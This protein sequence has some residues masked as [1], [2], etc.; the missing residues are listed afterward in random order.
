MDEDGSGLGTERTTLKR[1]PERGVHDFETIACILDE[2]LYCHI[3]F[4]AD[5]QP[6]V[7]PTAFGRSGRTLYIHGSAASR[8]L[9]ALS[10]G[11]SMCLTATL[12][13]GLV[14]A[15]SAFRHSMNY[16]AVMILGVAHEV[17]GEEKLRGLETITE[18]T[19]PGRW[20]DARPPSAKELK[21]TT[22]LK[23]DIEEASAKIRQGPPIDDEADYALPIW[24]GEIPLAIAVQEPV[25]DAK[26][27]P[28]VGLPAYLAD[29]RR[30][31]G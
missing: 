27:R 17:S 25:P 2:A 22:V 23:L 10:G 24:A 16:R 26:L 1:H 31:D 14:L 9:G 3:G 13:D 21:A 28:D 6:F 4:V 15:R 20:A 11:L 19:V 5:S 18:H 7:I 29:Y 30:S 8:T 12:I